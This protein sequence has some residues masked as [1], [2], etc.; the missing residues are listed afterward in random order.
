[1]YK[2]EC[3][4]HLVLALAV[5]VVGRFELDGDGADDAPLGDDRVH[6]GRRGRVSAVAQDLFSSAER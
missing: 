3:M 5:S 4:T 2:R 1:M 6:H